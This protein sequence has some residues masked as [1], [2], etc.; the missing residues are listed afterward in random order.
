[1]AGVRGKH[2]DDPAKNRVITK[3][4]D[5]ERKMLDEASERLNINKSEVIRQGIALMHERSLKRK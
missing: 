2:T 4:T 5:K 3:M 1:M